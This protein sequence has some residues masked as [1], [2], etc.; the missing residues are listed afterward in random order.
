MK[1]LFILFLGIIC[2]SASFAT[3]ATN[4]TGTYRN[5]Q[6]FFTWTNISPGGATYK[7]YRSSTIITQG[8]QLSSCEYL[9]LTNQTSALNSNLTN[10]D[11]ANRYYII[12]TGGSP[13]ASTQGLFVTTSVANA[14]YYYAV[15]TVVNSVEDTAIAVNT[16]SL[17]AAIAETVATPQPVLQEIRTIENVPVEIYAD[18]I[19]SKI[20]LNGPLRM[21]AGWLGYDFAVFRNNATTPQ[22]L[23][24]R[25][26]AGGVD[27]LDKITK[28]SS[29]EVNLGVEDKFPDDEASGWTGTNEAYDPY[30]KSNNSVWSTGTNYFYSTER[31]YKEINWMIANCPV[32]SN[33]I[34]VDGTSFGATGAFFFTMFHPEK[35]AAANLTSGIFNFGF[36]ND[37]IPECS[38][39][40]GQK[41]RNDGD[42]KFG[43]VSTNLPEGSGLSTYNLLNGGWMINHYNMKNWPVIYSVNGRYDTLLGWTEKTIWY[44][45]VENNHFGG[46]YFYDERDHAGDNKSWLSSNFDMYRYRK[47]LSY[48]AFSGCSVDNNPGNGNGTDGDP[49]GTCNGYLDWSSTITDDA[50][51]WIVKIY[52]R[53]LNKVNNV[54]VAAPSSCTATIT[55]R[56]LQQFKPDSGATLQWSVKHLNQQIQSGSLTYSGGLITIAGIQIYNDTITFQISIPSSLS[57]YYL[58]ADSDSYGNPAVSIHA[59]SQPEGYVSDNTDCND[60]NSSVHT[61]PSPTF[62]PSGTITACKNTSVKFTAS[63]GS[64]YTYKWYLNNVIISGATKKTYTSSGNES[65]SY[66]VLETNSGGCSAYSA[67]ATITRLPAPKASIVVTGD[68]NICGI[69]SVLLSE[70]NAIGPGYQWSKNSVVISGA[71]QVSYTVTSSGNYIV[72]VT[73]A[74]GCTKKSG[75]VTVTSS[76][77]DQ[78]IVSSLPLS[79]GV[80]FSPNPAKDFVQ[81]QIHVDENTEGTLHI[82]LMNLLGQPVLSANTFVKGSDF[83][84]QLSLKGIQGG[85]YFVKVDLN[86]KSFVGQLVI[87]EQ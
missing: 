7:L 59:S 46:Y 63:S 65:G 87:S 34:Y 67:A 29:T 40:P 10:H 21:K 41:N 51:N 16:N 52:T 54:V 86:G 2:F 75:Q 39:N 60:S 73:D 22:A 26:H 82:Q 55:L 72:T 36:Q 28:V 50:S 27:F 77:R 84:Q 71:T 18:F 35:I 56:R 9:G 14:S 31:I 58:D 80:A 20:S 79:I 43:Y 23:H 30:K 17:S 76:C 8:S 3:K 64:G 38:M 81:L 57:T 53:P 33:R 68:L 25:F 32:D 6:V 37:Y 4:F 12:Q 85:M 48:P 45:S 11:L 44:D 61:P 5:G 13:L 24:I 47:N 49:V 15:T 70:K 1:K 19:S 74:N 42:K 69:G 62:T 78:Q 66:K 83:A